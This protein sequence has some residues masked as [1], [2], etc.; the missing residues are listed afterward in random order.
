VH[1]ELHTLAS[2]QMAREW[3]HNRLQTT[4]IVNEAYIKL[5]SKADVRKAGYQR[6]LIS[7]RRLVNGCV[8]FADAGRT[9][10]M[11]LG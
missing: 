3:R 10:P 1:K 5:F 2:R 7:K 9:R 6:Q 4:V 11:S 8:F